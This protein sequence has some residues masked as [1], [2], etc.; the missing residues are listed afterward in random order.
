M[1]FAAW[2]ISQLLTNQKI[3]FLNLNLASWL[4]A[5]APTVCL[6][7]CCH[8]QYLPTKCDPF[9]FFSGGEGW[10]PCILCGDTSLLV[11]VCTGEFIFQA[12][13]IRKLQVTSNDRQHH[14]WHGTMLMCPRI[15]H[16]VTEEGVKGPCN[17]LVKPGSWWLRKSVWKN[18]SLRARLENK[19]LLGWNSV[20]SSQGLCLNT[21]AHNTHIFCLNWLLRTCRAE[22]LPWQPRSST[23]FLIFPLWA[24]QGL[25]AELSPRRSNANSSE[26][27]NSVCWA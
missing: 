22:L 7:F 27:P 5:W 17:Y 11:P 9:F 18:S 23:G 10:G 16:N 12:G 25:S 2:R 4:V 14:L 13:D 26:D 21:H 24:F 6:P 1:T 19:L 3:R 8:C 20:L 15:H